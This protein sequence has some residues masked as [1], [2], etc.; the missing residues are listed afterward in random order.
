MG[1][2]VI[3]HGLEGASAASIPKGGNRRSKRAH[4][5]YATPVVVASANAL[6]DPEG[7][8]AKAQTYYSKKH[9]G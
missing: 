5:T 3:G 2:P 9:P 7:N 6:T 1:L 8:L 4:K